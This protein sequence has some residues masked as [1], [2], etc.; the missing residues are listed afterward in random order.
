MLWIGLFFVIGGAGMFMSNKKGTGLSIGP[1]EVQQE[2][3]KN[4]GAGC[5]AICV[6]GLLMYFAS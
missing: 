1:H 5:L 6:G 4:Y 2:H 3:G